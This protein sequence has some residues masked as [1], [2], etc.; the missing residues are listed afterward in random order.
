MIEKER[1][2][3]ARVL[4]CV[5]TLLEKKAKDIIIINVR[6]IS[7]FTDY[8]VIC[9]GTSDRQVKAIASFIQES[10]KKSGIHPLG[11]EGETYGKWVLI[12][13]D[14]IIVHIFQEPVRTFYDLERLWPEA[15]RMAI[16]DDT[17]EVTFLDQSLSC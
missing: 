6:E 7:S 11:V 10:L 15:P 12:D 13:Y 1:E 5:N 4:L 16:S 9:S 14:D 8:F 2:A 3:E 17:T